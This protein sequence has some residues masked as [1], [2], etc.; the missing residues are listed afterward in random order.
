MPF[1]SRGAAALAA[2]AVLVTSA[3]PAAVATSADL[4]RGQQWTLGA[5]RIS[6]AWKLS[7]GDGVTVAVLDTGVDGHQADLTGRVIDGPDYTGHDRKPGS[8]YWGRHGTSM[9]SIIAGHGHG[10][11]GAAG[12]MGVAPEA[13]ILSI[14][15]TWELTDPTRS[16]RPQVDHARDA[17][18]R[19][20]RYAVDHGAQ[21]I[22]MSLGGGKLFYDGNPT[23]EA[24]IKYALSRNVVLVA[25]AGND[26]DGANRRNYPAA[27]PGV[28]AVGA[29]DRAF[30]PAKFT[31]RHSYVSVA[32]PG[33]EIVSADSG[34]HG[35]VLGTGTSPS[36]AFVA[37][38]SA[39]VKAR[40]H[41]LT[42]QEVEQAIEQG[43]SHRPRSGRTTR[44]GTGV[45]DAFGALRAAAKINKAEHGGGGVRTP[46]KAPVTRSEPVSA[47]GSHSTLIA[48]LSGGGVLIG[49]SLLLGWRQRRRGVETTALV[50][51]PAD[52]DSSG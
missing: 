33:V 12:I 9:A 23:E 40:Y 52:D 13:K 46:P 38:I 1:P 5:L 21:V 48:I 17:I 31:N 15:V 10:P 24:A 19:G 37:G 41:R 49:L 2:V 26:G 32:A 42:S 6:K 8:R 43:A 39:L 27:Y 44:I 16:E 28:V 25:S 14:R 47:G 36:A 4:Y 20:I 22:N 29:V 45:A 30:K 18:A 11:G 7:K 35:Y 51:A 50:T 34:G 3:Q